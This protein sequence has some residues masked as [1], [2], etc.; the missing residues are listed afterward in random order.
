MILKKVSEA[1]KES[2]A[3]QDTGAE[4]RQIDSL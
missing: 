3:E 4:L 2:E 1:E